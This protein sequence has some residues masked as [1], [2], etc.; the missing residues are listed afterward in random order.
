[1]GFVIWEK[2]YTRAWVYTQDKL[3]DSRVDLRFAHWVCT[4]TTPKVDPLGST[5]VLLEFATVWYFHLR[6]M[7]L[8]TFE[9]LPSWRLKHI[10]EGIWDISFTGNHRLYIHQKSCLRQTFDPTLGNIRILFG[11]CYVVNIHYCISLLYC[12]IYAKLLNLSYYTI[13]ALNLCMLHDYLHFIPNMCI[14]LNFMP[15]NHKELTLSFPQPE[16]R[17]LFDTSTPHGL[18]IQRL[19]QIWNKRMLHIGKP[20]LSSKEIWIFFPR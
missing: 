8:G 12:C 18:T 16:R 1:M 2:L 9:G 19:W 5:F 7:T 20:W 3:V 6:S 14:H 11:F 10:C 15:A 17:R 13:N 4:R